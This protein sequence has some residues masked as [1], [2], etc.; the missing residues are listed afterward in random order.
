MVI[1]DRNISGWWLGYPSEKWWSESQ[2]GLWFFQIYGK[3]NPNVPKHQPDDQW[4]SAI[5]CVNFQLRSHYMS[6]LC[7]QASS[8]TDE[9]LIRCPATEQPCAGH[10]L[11]QGR[12]VRFPATEKCKQENMRIMRTNVTQSS[13]NKSICTDTIFWW[14]HDVIWHNDITQEHSSFEWKNNL[15]I[16]FRMQFSQSTWNGVCSI[17]YIYIHTHIYIY[18]LSFDII[19]VEGFGREDNPVMTAKHIK[20]PCKEPW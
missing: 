5:H 17:E 20:E 11:W 1:N 9:Y 10:I 16:L 12:L 6:P 4:G 19:S 3:I 8:P 13:I 2:L 15:T 18:M 7:H 14:Y